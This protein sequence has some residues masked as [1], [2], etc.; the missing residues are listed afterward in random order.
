MEKKKYKKIGIYDEC[1]NPIISELIPDGSVCLDVGCWTGNMGKELIQNHGC[2]VDGLDL[3][4]EALAVAKERGFRKTYKIDLNSPNLNFSNISDKYDFIIFADVLEHL[5]NPQT[6]LVELSKNL[7]NKG[8]V[9]ISVPNICFI[10]YRL[11]HLF[12]NFNYNPQGGVMDSTH[13]KFFT[14]NTIESLCKNSGYQI[15][16]SVGYNLVKNKYFFLRILG[17]LFPELFA[18]QILLI[19]KKK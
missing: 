6:V 18:L 16:T 10:Y 19:L 13:L 3:N 12:G 4:E 14:K 2:I 9:V 17:N 1:F 7:N 5:I 15:N 8:T 11:T